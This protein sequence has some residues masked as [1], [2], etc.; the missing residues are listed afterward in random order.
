[1]E[2][3]EMDRR[4]DA[5]HEE[6]PAQTGGR[7]RRRLLGGA[8]GAALGVAAGALTWPSGRI[9]RAAAPT[10][11]QAAEWQQFDDAVQSAMQTFDMV[12]A[13]VAVVSAEG[14]L[15]SRTFGVR[16]RGSGAPVTPATLFR[17]GSTTRSMTSLLVAT[18]VD[19][20]RLAWDQPV[21]EAWPDFR[22]PTDE[23]THTLRVCDLLGMAS[24]LHQ[25]EATDL[26]QGYPTALE[27]LHSIASLPVLGPPSS[28][29]NYNNT[30]YAAAGY[31]PALSQDA[32]PDDVAAGYAHHMQERVFAPAGMR[33][34]R[35][36]DDPRPFTDDYAFDFVEGTAVEP[37]V[38]V[39]S[40]APSGG[41]MA[42]L[43]DMAAYVRLQLR[44]GISAAG[45]RVVSAAN[46]AECW[47]P[48][49]DAT[50]P[51]LGP[52]VISLGYGM[53]WYQRTYTDGRRLIEHGGLVDGFPSW[54]GFFPDD[55]LGLVVLTNQFH[56]GS[57]FCSYVLNLLL[58]AR[59]G[60]NRGA[61]ETA[62]T[63][64][65]DAFAHFTATAAQ[66]GPVDPDAIAPFL[67]YYER[68]YRLAYEATG[69]LRLHLSTRATRVLAMP[70]GSYVGASGALA[71]T[72]IRLN[73]DS[74]GVPAI[75]MEGF[76]TVRWLI[77]P[78]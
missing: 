64:Y 78:P 11:T 40:F 19:E 42:G 62:V 26:H 48:H 43:T 9:A 69:V 75:E 25:P 38:P 59:F 17:V 21:I 58:E 2:A 39:G 35:I 7:T 10:S 66:A 15:H 28:L 13:A 45:T 24:G 31:L 56:A 3:A 36:G 73:R 23:L 27:L 67:G 74:A 6:A 46:L 49:I 1:M 60:L 41:V 65:R 61:N 68:G 16:D 71:R 5:R 8:A 52:D 37:W 20:G 30:V 32:P 4:H 57:V 76:E 50:L 18:F 33:G 44:R 47:Q 54:I 29:Y 34:A 55:N 12:G 63:E 53:G 70:D 72:P 77:G 22:A 14:I 51:L